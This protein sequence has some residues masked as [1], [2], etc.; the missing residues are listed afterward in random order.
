MIQ[1]KQTLHGTKVFRLAIYFLS[2]IL[3]ILLIWLGGFVLRDIDSRTAPEIKEK[4]LLKQ[5]QKYQDQIA[6]IDKKINITEEKKK[7]LEDSTEASQNTLKQ[8][9]EL[10]RQSIEKSLAISPEESKAFAESQR[11]FLDNQ[12]QLQA[13]MS[14]I[15]ELKNEKRNYTELLGE[16][17]KEVN[18]KRNEIWRKHRRSIALYK[19][20]FITPFVLIGLWLIIWKRIPS[21]NPFIYAFDIAVFYLLIKIIHQHFPSRYYKYIFVIMAIIAVFVI[22]V[23]LIRQ[24]LRPSKNWLLK[25]YKEAYNRFHC[26]VCQYSFSYGSSKD[27]RIKKESMKYG[28]PMFILETEG[29]KEYRCPSCGTAIFESCSNCNHL[30]HSLLPYCYYCGNLKSIS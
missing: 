11:I 24:S 9:L 16:V 8:L 26:P 6:E 15:L 23:Y 30:R 22:L 21:R 2:I 29:L 17:N 10:R 4:D 27:S 20:L 12:K 25:K 18:Q 14:D 1:E 28:I 7:Y 13:I 3:T 19:V 5:K